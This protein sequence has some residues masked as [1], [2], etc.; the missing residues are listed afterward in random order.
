[1]FVLSETPSIA[2]QFLSELRD[3]N[4]QTDSMRFRTNLRRLGNILAYELSKNLEYKAVEIET[5][6]M[7]TNV[8]QLDEQVVLVSVLRASLPFYQGFLDFFDKAENGFIGAYRQ[9]GNKDDLEINL[10]YYASPNLEG[11][12]LVIV[13]PMLATGKSFIKSLE[14]LFINGKPRK[15]HIAA[16]VAAPEGLAYIKEN[17]SIPHQVWIG[18]LDQG[19]NEQ[20]YILPG[21][22]DAGDLAF[23]PKL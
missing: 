9:E 11:K 7:K 3:R 23:G 18:A 15:I 12:T 10:G 21:L 17:L 6:L 13:D 19:L 4:I 8:L 16:V 1:M 14:S 22:G 20:A 2:S 5:P